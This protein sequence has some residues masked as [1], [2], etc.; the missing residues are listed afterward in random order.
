MRVCPKCGYIDPPEWKHTRYSYWIDDCSFEN[1]KILFPD[2]AKIIKCK[3]SQIDD[4]Y[5]VYRHTLSK[6][7][8][9]ER[10]AKIDFVGKGWSDGTERYISPW[11]EGKKR[12]RL[13]P[14]QKKL[15]EEKKNVP[16]T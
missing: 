6:E 14:N 3:G 4:K 5:Y 11:G 10:K 7:G 16:S 1:F 15:F 12:F 8:W 13:H 2:L 9:V